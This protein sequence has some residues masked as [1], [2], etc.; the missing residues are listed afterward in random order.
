MISHL[1]K[2]SV[3]FTF[4]LAV[5]LAGTALAWYQATTDEINDTAMSAAQVIRINEQLLDEASSAARLAR[6]L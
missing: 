5:A 6:P 4:G 3:T 2:L 1:L